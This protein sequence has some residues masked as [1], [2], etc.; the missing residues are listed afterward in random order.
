M[1]RM[2]RDMPLPLC[3][4]N[5]AGR[6]L[7]LNR[8]VDAF[9]GQFAHTL[10]MPERTNLLGARAARQLDAQLNLAAMVVVGPARV[11]RTKE[12]D[13]RHVERGRKVPRPAVRGYD[14]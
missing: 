11:G 5:G 9:H 2:V 3:R 7:F 1:T 8:R 12:G 14:E 10:V 4:L 6:Q 13:G